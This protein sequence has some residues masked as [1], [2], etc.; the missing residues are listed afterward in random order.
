M[1][2]NKLLVRIGSAII[3]ALSLN[4]VP[5]QAEE[6]AEDD[7]APFTMVLNRAPLDLVIKSIVG[8]AKLNVVVDSKVSGSTSITCLLYTSPSPR[9][10]L[11]SRMPSS[12]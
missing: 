10:L 5:L 4:L 2:R 9:D 7:I 3:I 1:A 11:K 8:H 12:A 6:S